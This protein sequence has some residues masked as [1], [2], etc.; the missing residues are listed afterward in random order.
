MNALSKVLIVLILLLS[1][2]FAF[3][4]MILFGRREKFADLYHAE[5]AELATTKTQLS[6]VE[7]ELRD[8]TVESDTLKNRLEDQV[9][10]LA[11]DLDGEKTRSKDL[12]TQVEKLT[13]LV[14]TQGNRITNMVGD[15][16]TKDNTIDELETTVGE[17]DGTIRQ[18][19]DK[20]DSLGTTIAERD[21]AIGDLEHRLTESKKAHQQVT[22]NQERL[23]AIIGE[24]IAQG[25]QVPPTPPP[26]INGRVVRVNTERGIA[27]VDKGGEAGVKVATQFT[28]YDEAGYV[29]KV[30]IH[31]VQ[32]AV[33][34]GRVSLLADGK[35]VK[36]GD[37][38]T[39]EIP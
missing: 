14:Q 1:A 9:R 3:S 21:A 8:K 16:G 31:D 18:N 5:A 26:I 27:V 2:G 23:E 30:V 10:Q 19:L 28:I 6:R 11:N 22:L 12:N 17:R 13:T 39:T 15:I 33:A 29:G 24:L 38:A 37:R 20:I 34:A 4:Q 25:V 36:Q 35:E 32:S 7:G